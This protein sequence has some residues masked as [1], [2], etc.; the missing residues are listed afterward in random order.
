MSSG[1]E[2]AVHGISRIDFVSGVNGRPYSVSL[3][4]PLV[5]RG[6][7]SFPVLYVLDGN[8]YFASVVEAARANWNAPQ[9]AVVGIG[10][11][12]ESPFINRV[13]A[14]HAPLPEYLAGLSPWLAAC[15]LERIYDLT[16][17]ASEAVLTDQ[18]VGGLFAPRTRDV[19]G[20]DDFLTVLESEVK[21][22]VAS[23]VQVDAANQAIFGHSLGGLAVLRALFSNPNGFRTFIAASPSIWWNNL[24][25]LAKERAFSTL[26]C[27]GSARPRVLITM[28]GDEDLEQTLPPEFG[29]DTGEAARALRRRRMVENAR[30]L[31][32]RL[33]QLPGTRPYQ[34]ADYLLFP[35]VG[36]GLSPWLSIA[37]AIQFALER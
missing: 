27:D 25:V 7:K 23:V 9:L 17:P 4:L 3:A 10:Y 20:L 16:L 2:T 28:G 19:G 15:A 32:L 34:V 1:A 18:R 37:Y 13:L 30:E 8:Y 12:D 31:T 29:V 6:D 24:A 33:Q 5:N 11:P 22:R 14:R 26:V 36:H 21:T 35:H